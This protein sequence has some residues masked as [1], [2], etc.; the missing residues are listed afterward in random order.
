MKALL[1]TTSRVIVNQTEIFIIADMP[2]L[3]TFM[4]IKKNKNGFCRNA[5][6]VSAGRDWWLQN[7]WL[8]TELHPEGTE[9]QSQ[10]GSP[11]Y[12]A[13]AWV[14]V[15]EALKYNCENLGSV[16]AKNNMTTSAEQHWLTNILTTWRF[17]TPNK[18]LALLQWRIKG[19]ETFA[20]KHFMEEKKKKKSSVKNYMLD[21]KWFIYF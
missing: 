15:H 8:N 7:H 6:P 18:G 4:F 5:Y 13:Y 17:V 12:S 3:L 21:F 20:G 10:H 9:S 11:A 14:Q 1:T 19:S 2:F 16:T